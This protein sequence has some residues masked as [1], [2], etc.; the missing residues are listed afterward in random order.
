[1]T[2]L[3]ALA[4]FGAPV[5]EEDYAF[6][7]V[8]DDRCIPKIGVGI[9]PQYEAE[10]KR[11]T[12]PRHYRGTW[13]VDFETSF[14]T[15]TGYRSCLETTEHNPCMELSGE[16]LP[17]LKRWECGREFE[18]DFVGRRNVLPGFWPAYKIV[19]DK[20]IWVKRLPDP[21]DENCDPKRY[22][23]PKD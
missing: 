14:F 6:L 23:E 5:P 19:V 21:H 8:K 17:R 9:E 16:A 3:I 2:L 7:G 11:M 20:L 1:V 4:L 22:P 13:Y 18:V 10:C 15:P 12:E